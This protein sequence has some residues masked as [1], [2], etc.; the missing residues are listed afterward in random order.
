[1]DDIETYHLFFAD[2]AG[3]PGTDMTFFVFPGLPKG[4]KETNTISRTSFR[5]KDDD[6]LNYW[7]SRF[8]V[9]AIAHG[10]IQERFGK[11]YLE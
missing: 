3:S 10:E 7:V 2:V 9:Y 8:N 4:T 5:V 6:A 11:K 1:Q